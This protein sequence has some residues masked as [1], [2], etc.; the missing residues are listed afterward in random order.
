MSYL[1][2]RLEVVDVELEEVEWRGSGLA[3]HGGEPDVAGDHGVQLHPQRHRRQLAVF[4]E[5]VEQ[6]CKKG[7]YVNLQALYFSTGSSK[8]VIS[9][10][11]SEQMKKVL[12]EIAKIWFNHSW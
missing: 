8:S 12:G 10:L 6:G 9:T 2:A 11:V 5:L 3:E 1:E 4:V 7:N